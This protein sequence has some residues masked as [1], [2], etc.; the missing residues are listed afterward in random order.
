MSLGPQIVKVYVDHSSIVP[1]PAGTAGVEISMSTLKS[2]VLSRVQLFSPRDRL[3]Q[4]CLRTQER[5]SHTA[6][7]PYYT[8]LGEISAEA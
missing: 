5:S 2:N 4:P 7:R 8:E 6:S 1:Q 3:K